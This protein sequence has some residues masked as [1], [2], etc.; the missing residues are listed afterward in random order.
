MARDMNDYVTVAER[1]ALALDNLSQVITEPPVMLTDAMGYIRA[2]VGMKDGRSAT[3][4][5]SFRLD[6]QGK[7]A[8]ATNPIEDCETSAVGRALG[9]LGY[10]AKNGIASRDEVQEAQRR[11][12]GASYQQDAQ[13]R[14]ATNGAQL[15]SEAQRKKLFAVW[16]NGGYEGTLQDWIKAEYNCKVDELSLRDAS[17]AIETL[18]PKDA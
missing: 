8:Q 17:A 13:Q 4:T 9:M 10:G 7:T 14:P 18:Q 11:G 2:T 1:L 12:G 16:K 3:G 15:A 6:L 5:A